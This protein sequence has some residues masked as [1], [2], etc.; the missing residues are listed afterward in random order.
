MIP[1]NSASQKNIS[2]ATTKQEFIAVHSSVPNFFLLCLLL[3][4]YIQN[5]TDIW[6]GDQS[7][8]NWQ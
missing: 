7:F 4:N 5:T 6:Q 8:H 1:N 2:K 3:V